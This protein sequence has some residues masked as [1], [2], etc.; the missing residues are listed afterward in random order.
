VISFC[1]GAGGGRGSSGGLWVACAA[2]RSGAG[3]SDA[4]IEMVGGGAAWEAVAAAAPGAGRQSCFVRDRRGL[5]ASG[6]IN[7][8]RYIGPRR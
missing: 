1:T 3:R 5:L 4:G 7:I 2:W 8:T 6:S